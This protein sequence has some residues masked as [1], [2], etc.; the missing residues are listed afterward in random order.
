VVVLCG[1][2]ILPIPE[3]SLLLQFQ[4]VSRTHKY[5]CGLSQCHSG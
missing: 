5:R 3:V 1:N 4:P 2:N